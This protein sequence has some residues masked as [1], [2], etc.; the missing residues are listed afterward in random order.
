MAREW[1]RKVRNFDELFTEPDWHVIQVLRTGRTGNVWR[2]VPGLLYESRE[3][4][5]DG[6]DRIK[7]HATKKLPRLRIQRVDNLVSMTE[8]STRAKRAARLAAA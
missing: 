4:A 5:K 2:N 3:E 6:L 7:K 8:I 1:N